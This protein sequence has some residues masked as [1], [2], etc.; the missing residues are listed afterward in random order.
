M[1]IFNIQTISSNCIACIAAAGQTARSG[2]ILLLTI[3]LSVVLLAACGGGSG[4]GGSG[5][6]TNTDL[7]G[8]GIAD[9]ADACPSGGDT[10][11]TSNASTDND[12]D[13]C[14]DAGEDLDDDND[15]VAD[16]DDAF[17]TDACASVDTDGD[18]LPDSLVTGCQ[19][20]LREDPDDD[21]DEI[22][23]ETDV[24]DNNNSLIEI[25]TLDD[26]ARLRDNLN[27]NGTDDGMFPEITAMG[28]VG[29]PS[30]G[31]NGYELTRSLN[32]S[33]ADSYANRSKMD[34]WT[35]GRGWQPI[36][37][38][39][40]A[41][42]CTSY[43]GIFDGG[44]YRIA[45][46]FIS[47][48]NTTY[49][50][51]L[52]G[53]LTGDIQNLHLRNANV[54]GGATNVDVGGLVGYGRTADIRNASVSGGSVA[55]SFAVGG[56]VGDGEN[57]DIRYASVSG[58]SVAGNFSV[59]GL[60]GQGINA[61]IRYASVS[62]VN[63]SG[64]SNFAGGLVGY[65]ENASIRYASVS[66]G[67]VA[68]SIAAGGLVGDGR[69]ADIRNASVSGG[70]VAGSIAGGLVGNGEDAD[71]RYASVSGGNVSGSN[72]V[73]GLVGYGEDADIRY[74]SVSGVNVSGASSFAGGLVGYGEDADIRHVYVSG[75]SVKGTTGSRVGGLV[76]LGEE[77]QI[78][79]SYA[80]PGPVSAPNV[81]GGLI[82]ITDS[83]TNV[84]ATY[85]DNQT[86]MQ[87]MSTGNLGEGHSTTALQSP[88]EFA[89]SIYEVWGNFWCDPN[90]GEEMEDAT[91]DGPGASFIRVWDLGTSSQYPALNCLPGGLS[92]QG[93]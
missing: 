25:S 62:G 65:G 5:G 15:G 75:G 90:T 23:D 66:G 33:D 93:R 68:E 30:S 47:A 27:G 10:D 20:T 31:C 36:G 87:S 85:W 29:C 82:G 39:S 56:L 48:S 4:G 6:G 38:C 26:L 69:T 32:F 9:T 42:N 71:I 11:W 43:T 55:G 79:Y 8:D 49:G 18:E 50:V 89:G 45:D 22:L 83:E 16:T 2:I 41:N 70:S 67:S 1:N 54:N 3:T 37:S 35:T 17:R 13:G 74:A 7:D 59:G 80:A 78:N 19:T 84:I 40:S 76:G 52:F 81:V 77:V 53:A 64:R 88:T 34:V 24:D 61:D 91:D 60:V 44:G 51:G 46:L 57:A 92:A 86:T 28:S 63:V 73:G 14:R 12:R 72:T 58:V 21:N